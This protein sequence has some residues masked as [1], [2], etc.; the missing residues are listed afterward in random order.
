[1]TRDRRI[2]RRLPGARCMVLAALAPAAISAQSGAFA[3]R[4]EGVAHVPGQGALE[5]E[6]ALDSGAAG[7]QG[8][9]RV[10]ARRADPFPFSSIDRVQ[11]SRVSAC[12]ISFRAAS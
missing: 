8:S 4:W 5:V 11:D 3:G 10:P 7:W 2:I 6:I 9:F 1:M 12:A